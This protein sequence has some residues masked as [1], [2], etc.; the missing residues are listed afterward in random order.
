MHP[1]CAQILP[2]AIPGIRAARSARSSCARPWGKQ[3]P[4]VLP[5]RRRLSGLPGRWRARCNC[6]NSSLTLLSRETS[7]G[8]RFLLPVSG[9]RNSRV[10]LWHTGRY[11][12]FVF[13]LFQKCPR[14]LYFED[15]LILFNDAKL[16]NAEEKPSF[17]GIKVQR[18]G[19]STHCPGVK[20]TPCASVWGFS[21]GG[22]DFFC[23]F[24]PF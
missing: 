6:S 23:K 16:I 9:M 24:A 4:S 11:F 2:I 8:V 3:A 21:F 14:Q 7:C 12:L 20:N 22:N 15:L 19:I 10:L 17:W 13:L 1:A 5:L 18:L